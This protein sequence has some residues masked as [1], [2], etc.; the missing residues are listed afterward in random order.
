MTTSDINKRSSETE[1]LRHLVPQEVGK[2]DY[3]RMTY[4]LR[5]IALYQPLQRHAEVAF[6]VLHVTLESL[7]TYNARFMSPLNT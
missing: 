1:G 3:T 4:D 6:C 2:E 5:I 7:K